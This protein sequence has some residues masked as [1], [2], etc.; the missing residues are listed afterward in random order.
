[1]FWYAY[2]DLF[3]IRDY[4]KTGQLKLSEIIKSFRKKKAYS[5]WLIED[6]KPYFSFIKKVFIKVI[7]KVLRIK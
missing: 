6:P 4:I 3:A 5:I 1:V 2:E 7:K